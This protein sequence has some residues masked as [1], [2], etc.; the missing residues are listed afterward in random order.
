[1]CVGSNNS[2]SGSSS[3]RNISLFM[4]D[5]TMCGFCRPSIFAVQI[6][7][8]FRTVATLAVAG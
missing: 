8:T 3:S 6:P 7:A 5:V 4:E 1:M 2:S